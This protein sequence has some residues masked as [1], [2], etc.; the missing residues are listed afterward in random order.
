MKK[1]IIGILIISALASAGYYLVSKRQ[2]KSLSEAVALENSGNYSKALEIYIS[3]LKSIADFKDQPNKAMAMT[4]SPDTWKKELDNYL[5]WLINAK[6][7]QTDYLQNITGAI[8]RC[9]KHVVNPNEIEKIESNKVQL[10]DYQKA[11]NAVFYPTGKTPPEIQEQVIEKAIDTSV[12]ILTL[13]GNAN[14]RY[15]G[16]IVN[17][18]TGKKVD[19]SVFNDGSASLLT[20]PGNYLL[21]VTGKAAFPGGKVWVSPQGAFFFSAPDTTSLI[22]I[23]LKTDVRRK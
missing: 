12:S 21:I 10:A 8:D 17:L 16:F 4:A 14:Y 19:F 5:A 13:L 11:W 20:T 2:S 1:I 7:F 18:S 9:R 3:A 23:K 6:N 15:D 22:S